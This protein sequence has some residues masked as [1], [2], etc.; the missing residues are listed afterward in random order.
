MP[1]CLSDEDIQ[2]LLEE[3]KPLPKNYVQRLML[4]PKRGHKEREMQVK[5]TS[6]SDFR[7]IVRQNDLNPLDFSVILAY[8]APNSNQFFRLRRYNGKHGEHT[9]K[10]EEQR[11]YNFHVHTATERYQA[12]G[13][14]R[15][16]RGHVCRA[17]E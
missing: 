5:G 6:G 15:V 1:L 9:N 11:F 12:L 14:P 4:K 17:H 3:R 13:F 16:S 8:Q 10:L 7:V 2:R